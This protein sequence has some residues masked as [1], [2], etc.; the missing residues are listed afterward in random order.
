MV[1]HEAATH[2]SGAE[3]AAFGM[4][5]LAGDP[6]GRVGR[7]ERHEL[8]RI[9]GLPNAAAWEFDDSSR[10]SLSVIYPVSVGPGLTALAVM[11][12]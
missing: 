11:P 9:L 2:R 7:Q 4:D 8:R 3:E 5:N 6:S 10:L 1:T 12:L